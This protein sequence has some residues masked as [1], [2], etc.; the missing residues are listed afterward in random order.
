MTSLSLS[1][2]LSKEYISFSLCVFMDRYANASLALMLLS[3]A[4][5]MAL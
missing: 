1:K 4:S 2:C 3:F 5:G